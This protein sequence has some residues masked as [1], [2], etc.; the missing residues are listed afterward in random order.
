MII[1]EIRGVP[2]SS[3]VQRFFWTNPKI[4]VGQIGNPTQPKKISQ[5]NPLLFHWVRVVP[6]KKK[7]I[8]SKN[9]KIK[10]S[11]NQKIKKSKNQNFF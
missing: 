7:K 9:Q 8:K 5:P 4:R 10:K 3:W 6:K 11:K 2:G 1:L